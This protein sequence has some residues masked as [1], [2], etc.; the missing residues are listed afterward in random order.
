M[1]ATYSSEERTREESENADR[2]GRG[3]DVGY[4]EKCIVSSPDVLNPT[5]EAATHSQNTN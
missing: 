1:T 5:V 4:S 2:D 3:D